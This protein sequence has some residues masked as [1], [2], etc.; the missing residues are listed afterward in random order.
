MVCDEE[1][2]G[3]WETT[4]VVKIKYEMVSWAP[5]HVGRP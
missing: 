1:G 5:T 3:Q 2:D 4:P